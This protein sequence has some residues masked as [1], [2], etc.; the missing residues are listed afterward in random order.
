MAQR[1]DPKTGMPLPSGPIAGGGSKGGFTLS[2][3]QV[4]KPMSAPPPG[5]EGADLKAA[6]SQYVAQHLASLGA[7][8]HGGAPH[9]HGDDSLGCGPSEAARF[10][11]EEI[12]IGG[13]DDDSALSGGAS[14]DAAGRAAGL[15]FGGAAAG[16]VALPL[17][18]MFGMPAFGVPAAHAAW[19]GPGAPGSPSVA[20]PSG[21]AGAADTAGGPRGLGPAG[22]EEEQMSDL[23][24]M[25]QAMDDDEVEIG[26]LAEEDEGAAAA[27]LHGGPGSFMAG[28]TAAAAAA[29]SR[30]MLGSGGGS[31]HSLGGCASPGASSQASAPGGLGSPHHAGTP[32]AHIQATHHAPSPLSRAGAVSPFAAFQGAGAGGLFGGCHDELG[33][34]AGADASLGLGEPVGVPRWDSSVSASSCQHHGGSTGGAPPPA[35]ALHSPGLR[36]L[37]P[38]RPAAASAGSLSCRTEDWEEEVKAFGSPHAP[39]RASDAAAGETG[40]P[41]QQHPHDWAAAAWAAPQQ[42]GAGGQG[43]PD[44]APSTPVARRGPSDAAAAWPQG[45]LRIRLAGVAAVAAQQ[46]EDAANGGTPVAASTP[47][48][49]MGG[50]ALGTPTAAAAAPRGGLPA[51]AGAFGGCGGGAPAGPA[52]LGA[53]AGF[54]RAPSGGLG[55]FPRQT[56]LGLHDSMPL[57][58]D[59]FGRAGSIMPRPSNDD[60]GAFEALLGSRGF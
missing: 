1:I 58:W 59:A 25:F 4:G 5:L 15:C 11:S 14:L 42:Q 16:A 43:T 17:P 55:L 30:G 29:L 53:A 49:D 18:A 57:E 37:L 12:L 10:A 40:S 60:G 52:P 32:L 13:G 33:A 24:G 48:I 21:S 45:H 34:A 2:V 31:R 23:E 41:E 56:S 7:G 28:S 22:N 38:P 54:G 44:T 51:P 26:D 39:Q 35:P 27:S 47:G 50:L 19:G 6:A 36:H 46:A 20:H 3:A 9:A 8:A